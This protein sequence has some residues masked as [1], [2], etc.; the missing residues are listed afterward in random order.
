M[1]A[2]AVSTLFDGPEK[3]LQG[4]THVLRDAELGQIHLHIVEELSEHW[5]ELEPWVTEC[6][7][8]VGDLIAALLNLVK[9]TFLGDKSQ[10]A[11]LFTAMAPLFPSEAITAI[12][13]LLRDR[14]LLSN[15]WNI[16]Y[17]LRDGY[18]VFSQCLRENPKVLAQIID[19]LLDLLKVDDSVTDSIRPAAAKIL[20]Q[21]ALT[22]P[23]FREEIASEI[24]PLL[25]DWTFLSGSHDEL[26]QL[27]EAVG[28]RIRSFEENQSA[29]AAESVNSLSDPQLPYQLD[30]LDN[31]ELL[32]GTP[33]PTLAIYC[34]FMKSMGEAANPMER[35]AAA[36]V[37]LE[38][39]LQCVSAW[40]E[41]I[42]RRS[43]VAIRYSQ[44][45]EGWLGD[46]DSNPHFSA[47][48]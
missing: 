4:V 46:R 31:E 28:I 2:R 40:G 34:R 25:P 10:I 39:Y 12:L 17:R 5:P 1:S 6:R 16:L 11:V 44:L 23:Q 45:L 14:N 21:L 27:A 30:L 33:L 13:A 3:F 38:Q 22:Y 37:T 41:I 9:T 32:P 24:A 20:E 29:S 48:H 18:P 8:A 35:M 7:A 26:V 43:D 36:G 47:S 19:V 15:Q 42:S